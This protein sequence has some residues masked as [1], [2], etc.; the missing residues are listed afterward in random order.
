MSY[1]GEGVSR[2]AL[3]IGDDSYKYIL[4][5]QKVLEDGKLVT[6]D[7]MFLNE[8]IAYQAAK[9]LE[10]P[11]P[12]A[13]IAHLD[14]R[15]I[16]ADPQITFVHRF[17]SGVHFASKE[18]SKKEENLKENYLDLLKMRKP[19]VS[20]S[21]KRFFDNIKNPEDISRIIAFDLLIANFDR[22]GNT[23]NL[24]IAEEN[25][26][27]KVFTIDHGHS[28]FGPTWNTNKINYLKFPSATP[29]YTDTFVNFILRNNINDGSVNGLGE[30]FR[31]IENNIELENVSNHSFQDA[32]SCIE[33]LS[34]AVVDEW[35]SAIP[36]TWFVDKNSQ[37]AYY[38]YFIMKQKDLVRFIIQRLADREAFSNF[39][40]GVLEWKAARHV[41]TV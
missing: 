27:R 6:Y 16:D 39:R 31:A 34:E 35:F 21:W 12:D 19:Y 2:P 8:L 3:I 13:A 40:G 20:R 9:F 23:G 36:N 33:G 15:L 30:V 29:E 41:G 11:V 7:C 5:T 24:L 32:V 28:F 22:Y 25:N 26:E 37:I 10:V 14:Q 18:L 17:Y 38:K 4:K 1:L